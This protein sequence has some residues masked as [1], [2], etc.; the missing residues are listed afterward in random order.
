MSNTILTI[1]KKADKHRV[2]IKKGQDLGG[3]S[4]FIEVYLND[5][6]YPYIV[7]CMADSTPLEKLIEWAK[8]QISK[9][10]FHSI[11]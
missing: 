5:E 9:H 7:T 11:L 10:P 1:P 4:T 6:Q 2:K 8:E 3:F